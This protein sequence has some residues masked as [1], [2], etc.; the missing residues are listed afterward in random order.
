MSIVITPST[1]AWEDPPSVIPDVPIKRLKVDQYEEMIR[2]G[3]I[4]EDDNVELLEGWLVPKMTKNPPHE[5]AIRLLRRALMKL[6]TD[7]WD[8]DYQSPVKL[9]DSVPE[10]DITVLR[11]D[12]SGYQGRHPTIDD[13]GLIVEIA[14]SSLGRDRGAKLRAYARA[15]VREYWIV[16]LDA[17]TFEVYTAP[18]A[19]AH[20]ARYDQQQ[21]Y[22][23]GDA[24]PLTLAGQLIGH[25]VVN[26]VL[27]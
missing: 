15:G 10:P 24:V 9:T 17:A 20:R 26:D 22:G 19:D 23:R 1:L 21:N 27:P 12:E 4:T 11:W 14:E 16:N 8:L 5:T 18:N 13:V 7:E 3:I 2:T 25:I 6:L